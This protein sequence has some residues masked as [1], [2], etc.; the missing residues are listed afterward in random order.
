MRPQLFAVI[1]I[2]APAC[3]PSFA[4]PPVIPAKRDSARA[5]T[6][7]HVPEPR[8]LG[9][10]HFASRN[11]AMTSPIDNLPTDVIPAKAGTQ[12]PGR[13]TETL[14]GASPEAMEDEGSRGHE[15]RGSGVQEGRLAAPAATDRILG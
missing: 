8:P 6:Q 7:D 11:P 13:N 12:S 5:G 14:A 2:A 10:G 4:R 3:P 9:P 15:G 1:A